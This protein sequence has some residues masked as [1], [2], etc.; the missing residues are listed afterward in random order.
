MPGRTLASF[1]IGFVNDRGIY[2]FSDRSN[3]SLD[4]FDAAS[5]TFI[6]RVPGF[7]GYD[8]AKG[9]SSAGPNGVVA[10]GSREFWAGNGDSTLKVVDL[11]S[12][13]I[14]ASIPTGGRKRVDEMTYDARD[15]LVIAVNNADKPPFVSFVSTRTRRVIGK[16]VLTRATDGAEQ[17][18]WDPATGLVYLSIPV[19]DEVKADGA[20]AVIDPRTHRLEKFMPVHA[21]MPAGLAVG[22]HG[23]LLVGC[24]D[25]AVAAGFAPKSLIL[26]ART[27][28]IVATI[29]QV[30]GSDEVWY[31]PKAH[32]YYLA[33]GGFPS[34]PVLGVVNA[35]T[36]RWIENLPTGS[37]AHSVAADPR[38]GRVF[39]P[40]QADPKAGV[41]P[42]GC[43][44]VFAP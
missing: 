22:P 30:G 40:I 35:N 31:D 5:A 34:G 42:A 41:C 24:S 1:D 3:R 28:A 38:T 27:G 43:V 32:R 14:V 23:H 13:S 25:D 18:A 29:R 10:V 33:A 21:C 36:D 17:P 26:N 20:V 9:F 44:A 15:H 12:K 19:L 8:P 7:S 39:V 2:A 37:H 6:G 16:L 4:L 11:R